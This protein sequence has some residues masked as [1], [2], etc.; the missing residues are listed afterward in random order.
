MVIA[1]PEQLTVDTLDI[2]ELGSLPRP[3]LSV[4]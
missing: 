1:E 2:T 4:G 3:R